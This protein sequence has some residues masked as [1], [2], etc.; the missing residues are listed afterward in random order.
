MISRSL[1]PELGAPIG[2]LFAFANALACSLNTVGFAETVRD[3]LK[4][5]HSHK[6]IYLFSGNFRDLLER[7]SIKNVIPYKHFQYFIQQP[8]EE[9]LRLRM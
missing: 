6:Y 5:R 1:G 8:D 9:R 7:K 2:L 4:V 3:V